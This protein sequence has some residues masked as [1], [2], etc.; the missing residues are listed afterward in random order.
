MD[1]S[2]SCC[3]TCL[4]NRSSY[5]D[6]LNFKFGSQLLRFRA[7]RV[8]YRSSGTVRADDSSS[9]ST[10]GRPDS[11]GVRE[12]IK[13]DA[14]KLVGD[15]PMVYLTRLN[16]NCFARIA[17]KLESMEPLSS[18]KDRIAISMIEAAERDGI[19]SPGRTTLVEPTSGNTGVGLAYIAAA[20]G[21]KLVLTMPSTMSLERRV[22]LLG[23]GAEL[24]LTEDTKGMEGAIRK[25]QDIAARTPGAY[26]LQQFENPANVDVHY[27][28]TGPEIWRDTA[29]TLDF[30]VAGVGTGGTLMGAGKFLRELKPSVSLVAVEPA[31][32]AVLSGG[33]A[34]FHQ[35]QGIGAGFIPKLVN[36]DMFSEVIQVTSKDALHMARRLAL[37]EGLLCGISSGAAVVAALQ[38]ARRKE[39]EGKLVVAVLASGG[40][41]YLSTNLFQNLWLEDSKAEDRLPPSWRQ[42]S[43]RDK[44][45][46]KD[47]RL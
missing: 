46:T 11:K 43:G 39:N 37:E 45:P 21:Y 9:P 1:P 12:G 3:T 31:E 17:C 13:S 24:I 47:F 41:R 7:R 44:G 40:E 10:S 29:G 18:V 2:R 20:K 35:I 16:T 26:L 19:I 34:G 42:R 8:M 27:N 23:L 36:V 33:V 15:T 4:F 5:L 22:L 30:L 28:T 14:T 6:N 32:S 25:A 38:I